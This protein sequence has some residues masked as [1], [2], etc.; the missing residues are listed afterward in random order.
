MLYSIIALEASYIFF[1]IIN[2]YPFV[3]SSVFSPADQFLLIRLGVDRNV[4]ASSANQLHGC[5]I[6]ISPV[7]VRY[8]V[9]YYTITLSFIYGVRRVRARVAMDTSWLA[10]QV[11]RVERSVAFLRQDQLA[12]LEGLHVEILSLQKRCTDLTCELELQPPRRTLAEV[13]AEE[14]FLI[15]RCQEVEMRLEEEQW[16]VGELQQEL[17]QKGALVRA[18]RCSLRDEERRFL[19][20][21]KQRSHR[22][23][24]LRAQLRV[25]TEAAAYLAFQLHSARHHLHHQHLQWPPPPAPPPALATPPAPPPALATPPAQRHALRAER[26]RECVPRERVTAPEDPTPMPDPALFLHPRRGRPRPPAEQTDGQE[27]GEGEG[28]EDGVTGEGCSG[29]RLDTACAAMCHQPASRNYA[30]ESSPG[31]VDTPEL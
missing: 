11:E 28:E 26:A 7:P 24:E 21:L 2:K 12:L 13:E 6:S 16:T 30:N 20:E 10:L 5:G 29:S 14:E 15:G 27:E 25:Q 9:F 3:E 8:V 31:D 4:N 17:S 22:S 18:L 19:Q 23:A 1:R